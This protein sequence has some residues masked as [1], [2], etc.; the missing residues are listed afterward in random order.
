MAMSR[1][2]IRTYL[3]GCS[4]GDRPSNLLALR[5][6]TDANCAMAREPECPFDANA[7]RVFASS[8]GTE[9]TLGYLGRDEAAEISKAMD[10]D[11][12]LSLDRVI[13]VGGYDGK[14]LGCIVDITWLS[15]D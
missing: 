14:R 4:F 1:H 9:R 11:W 12:P 8:H 5:A 15:P 6:D 2:N 7:I 13:P 3:K 10:G